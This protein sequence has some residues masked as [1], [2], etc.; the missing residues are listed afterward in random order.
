MATPFKQINLSTSSL[1]GM[2]RPV[3]SFKSF[4]K[5]V[6]PNPEQP[7]NDKPL[8]P[9]PS[10]SQEFV[11]ASQPLT[12]TLEFPKRSASDASWKAPAEWF[13]STP[14]IAKTYPGTPPLPGG[15]TLSPVI[16]E[17]LFEAGEGFMEFLTT[18]TSPSSPQVSRLLPIYERSFVDLGPPGSPPR[19][20]LPLPPKPTTNLVPLPIPPITSTS[21]VDLK[22]Y[23]VPTPAVRPDSEIGTDAASDH[24]S[25]LQDTRVD[26]SS[27]SGGSAVSD[28]ST[29]EKAFSSLGLD[30]SVGHAMDDY[31]EHHDHDRPDRRYM[32]G[33]KLRA[34]NKGNPLSDDSWED[35][36]LDEKA[37]QLSFSQ[38]YHDLLVDQYQELNVRPE[39]VLRQAPNDNSSFMVAG[40]GLD[41]KP[42]PLDQGLMPRP[43]SW[44]KS[45]NDSTPRCVSLNGNATT[46]TTGG[47][48]AN[49]R[50]RIS[51]KLSVWIPQRLSV[52]NRSRQCKDET[53]SAKKQKTPKESK[54]IDAN[55]FKAIPY[56]HTQENT[57]RDSRFSILPQNKP[58]L[59]GR[60]NRSSKSSD[61]SQERGLGE[62]SPT[63]RSPRHM[64]L[65]PMVRLPGGFAVVRTPPDPRPRSKHASLIDLS[66]SVRERPIS[67][68]FPESSS[69]STYSESFLPAPSEHRMSQISQRSV[70]TESRGLAATAAARNKLRVSM[71]SS[72]SRRSSGSNHP[73][74]NEITHRT[75]TSSLSP[76]STKSTWTQSSGDSASVRQKPGIFDKAMQARR[77][78]S[79]EL[80]QKRLK[81]S[82]KVLGPTDPHV[83]SGYIRDSG[84]INNIDEGGRR[85]GYLV[86]GV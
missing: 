18:Q 83:V 85:P 7:R 77:R 65:K 34:L 4:I 64:P 24:P 80:R 61:G 69:V 26:G 57:S 10:P 8:P 79:R 54:V 58:L 70:L 17:P 2:E 16:P 44:Q 52:G 68:A 28:E 42:R 49:K 84:Q 86:E 6:P 73:L 40:A 27:S 39:E 1:E 32:R 43:L 22:P 50:Y 62:P 56:G 71:A 30:P 76:I 23:T 47:D 3:R 53:G 78:R 36:D 75:N 45:S 21:M 82:I 63:T 38:D 46:V 51:G 37:R 81:N 74:A 25:P 29:K 11:V 9:T 15:R 33:R 12:P 66:S 14:E 48:S 20:P 35:P 59:F 55:S 60:K 41:P 5:T 72:Q 19:T 67:E 13:N 31:R